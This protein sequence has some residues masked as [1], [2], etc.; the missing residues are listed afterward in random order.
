MMRLYDYLIVG[1]GLAGAAAAETL[2]AGDVNGAIGLVGAEPYP[3]YYRPRLPGNVAGHVPRATVLERDARWASRL[4]VDLLLGSP[5]TVLDI[6]ARSVVLADGTRIG[7]HALL[8]ATGARP[9]LLGVPGETLHGVH[10]L[11]TLADADGIVRDLAGSRRTLVVGGGFIGAELCEALLARGLPVTYL[12]RGPRWFYP[13]V[14]ETAGRMVEDELRLNGVDVRFDVEVARLEGEA[15]RVCAAVASDGREFGGDLVACALGP[16]FDLDWL[17]GSG[18]ALGRGVLTDEWLATNVPGIWAAGDIADVWNPRV[19]GRVKLH[20][21]A[22]AG[23]QGRMAALGMLGRREQLLKTPQ[24]GFRLFGLFLVFIGL[25]NTE[26]AGLESW[27]HVEQAERAYTRLFL[28][29]GRC[30][31]ALLVNSRRA[32]R[33]RRLIEEQSPLPADLSALF[34]SRG[35]DAAG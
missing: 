17:A 3:P 4:R 18:L 25:Q 20:N 1:A 9:R 26:V 16:T 6:A 22:S 14:D 5:A 15:G 8:I 31:G 7:Y 11:W 33:V 23:L 24:Y 13:F 28:H 34:G 27:V 30:V 2:R 32:G 29:E 21:T 12:I 19:G 10:R 35:D